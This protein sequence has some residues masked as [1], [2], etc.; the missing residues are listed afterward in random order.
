MTFA[1]KKAVM[2]IN[3]I[4]IN[5]PTLIQNFKFLPSSNETAGMIYKSHK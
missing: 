1:I 2:G 4:W 5:N 3:V